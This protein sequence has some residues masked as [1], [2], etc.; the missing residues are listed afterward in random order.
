MPKKHYLYGF[1]YKEGE[2]RAFVSGGYFDEDEAELF[3]RALIEKVTK[4]TNG[5]PTYVFF[6]EVDP[7]Q[8]PDMQSAL[9]ELDYA[10]DYPE[11]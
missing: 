4:S 7:T 9:R 6:G 1:D 2:P 10:L 11:D 8:Q 3:E 5:D